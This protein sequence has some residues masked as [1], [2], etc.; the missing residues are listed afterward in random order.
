MVAPRR[1]AR[2]LVVD[3][4]ALV[5]DIV[6]AILRQGGHEVSFAEDG[7]RGVEKFRRKPY[8]LVIIDM[9]MPGMDG[10]HALMEMK[11]RERGIPVIAMSASESTTGVD[12][13]RLA[14]RLGVAHTMG[15]DFEPGELLR[16]VASLL[17]AASSSEAAPVS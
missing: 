6:A 11:P 1:S 4:D 9:V 3:D 15:K 16:I 13:L 17:G 5:R 8:D 14:R 10:L 7:R 2:I 12:T